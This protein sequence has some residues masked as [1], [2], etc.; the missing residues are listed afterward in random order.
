MERCWS[1]AKHFLY[2]YQRA[3]KQY[4]HLYLKEKEWRFNHQD[5]DIVDMV[6]HIMNLPFR[7]V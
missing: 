3:D 7:G 5:Q 6:R 1:Y 2:P 4:V